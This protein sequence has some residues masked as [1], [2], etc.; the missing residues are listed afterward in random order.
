MKAR[1]VMTSPVITVQ[2]Q[3]PVHATTALLLAH[4]FTAVPVVDRQSH[5]V[6]IVTEADLARDQ[7]RPEGWPPGQ[8]EPAAT[9]GE[10][11][12]RSPLAMSPDSDLAD[13]VSVMLASGIRSVPIVDDGRLVGIVSRRDVLAVIV[14]GELSAERVWLPGAGA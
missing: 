13:L 10:V 9:T 4:G 2:P 12:T 1:D 3:T 7:V 5:V 11:M 8:P 14:R 6:G